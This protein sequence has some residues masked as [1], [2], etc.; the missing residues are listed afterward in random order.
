MQTSLLISRVR[1]SKH[2]FP[3]LFFTTYKQDRT[4]AK[5]TQDTKANSSQYMIGSTT[6]DTYTIRRVFVNPDPCFHP[7]TTMMGSPDFMKPRAL[8][9]LMPAFTRASTSFSQ[10]GSLSA[11]KNISAN[12]GK[13]HNR[14]SQNTIV[15]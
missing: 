1:H 3:S 13:S 10:S 11:I 4:Q 9:K 5:L 12:K 6:S 14:L 2:V 15:T 8:P 7:V